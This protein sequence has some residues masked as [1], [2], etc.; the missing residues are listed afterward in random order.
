MWRLVEEFIVTMNRYRKIFCLIQCVVMIVLV[1]GIQNSYAYEEAVVPAF[2]A[3]EESPQHFLLKKGDQFRFFR[4][5]LVCAKYAAFDNQRKLGTEASVRFTDE[6][7]S[8][9]AMVYL[10][11][12]LK[13]QPYTEYLLTYK[14][15]VDKIVGS[16]PYIELISLDCHFDQIGSQRFE[17]SADSNHTWLAQQVSIMTSADT[18]YFKLILHTTEKGMALFWVDEL[19]LKQVSTEGSLRPIQ[20]ALLSITDVNVLNNAN[21]ISAL[22]SKAVI[23]S[24]SC[25][26]LFKSFEGSSAIHIDW[27]SSKDDMQ[28]LS[29]YCILKPFESIT[30][31]NAGV[32]TEWRRSYRNEMDHASFQ[33]DR[34][35]APIKG[36]EYAVLS[37]R[38]TIPSSAKYVRLRIEMSAA[39]QQCLMIKNVCLKAE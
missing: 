30:T 21:W 28:P 3:Q 26:M 22:P 8:E 27:L 31:I 7:E 17:M 18:N 13:V 34:Y 38:L 6:S 36:A 33:L 15:Y 37:R 10:H 39:T 14:R 29:D 4:H 16:A 5:N 19:Y 20:T 32:C 12:Q 2:F 24:L 11:H 23:C 9:A 25:N 1:S 35:F